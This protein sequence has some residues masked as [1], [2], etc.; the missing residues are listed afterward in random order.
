MCPRSFTFGL[1]VKPSNVCK[2]LSEKHRIPS[3]GNEYCC[4]DKGLYEL[5]NDNTGN[6]NVLTS[7]LTNQ[8]QACK[9][10]E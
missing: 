10:P 6:T 5:N 1:C 8:N 3:Q 4:V 2:I 9:S 7:A